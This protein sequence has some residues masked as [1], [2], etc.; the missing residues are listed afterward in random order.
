MGGH[1]LS[2]GGTPQQGITRADTAYFAYCVI[3]V[4]GPRRGAQMAARDTSQ[5]APPQLRICI[6]GAECTGKTTLAEA[7]GSTLEVPVTHEHV[8]EYFA[9]KA[10]R[11]DASVFARDIVHAVELQQQAEASAPSDAPII[12]LD[13]D[14]FTI[15]VW[16]QYYLGDRYKDLEALVAE[17]QRRDDRTD[18]YVLTAP[19][20]PFEHD[21]VRTSQNL[22]DRMHHL[23]K[24]ELER[25]GRRYVEVRGTV[26]ERIEQVLSA[27]RK[28]DMSLA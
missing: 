13:T 23:F 19:D 14:L 15:S 18:L 7:L 2:A 20:I 10:R 25:T 5:Y 4:G 9:E 26:P 24:A 3:T 28:I 8:R 6:T 11:G 1:Y 27:L 17:E 16:Q 22:R 21:G 12:V